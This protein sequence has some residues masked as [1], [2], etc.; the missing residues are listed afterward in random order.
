MAIL[1][2]ETMLALHDLVVASRE[3]A[4]RYE[5]VAQTVEDAGIAERLGQLGRARTAAA[6]AL[7]EIIVSRDDV[8]GAPNEESELLHNALAKVKAAL[9]DDELRTLLAECRAA[10]EAVVEA[11]DH[12][13]SLEAGAPAD[14]LARTLRD[15]A[16][17]R[18]HDLMSSLG[19]D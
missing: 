3:A 11:A 16:A 7:A 8:P 19:G 14:D 6:D 9:S 17:T 15:D 12:L 1:R 4:N 13:L 18:I 5:T 10:D 2:D